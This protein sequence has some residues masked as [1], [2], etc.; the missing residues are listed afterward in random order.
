MLKK[1]ITYTDFNDEKQTETFYFNLSKA[2]LAEMELVTEGG[3]VEHLTKIATEGAGGPIIAEF[4]NLLAKSYGVRSEDGKRFIKDPALYKE[5]TETGAYSEFFMELVTDAD[6]ASA[7]INAL[8]PAD[9][10]AEAAKDARALSEAKMQGYKKAEEKKESTME[11]TPELP[12][13]TP[14][15][16]KSAEVDVSKLSHEELLAH[17]QASQNSLL[18]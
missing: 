6:A 10:A 17:V 5:F 3:Y 18:K 4:K 14:Q 16:E 1:T 2:E 12:A 8:I 11:V 13:S 15:L 9:L 7:L